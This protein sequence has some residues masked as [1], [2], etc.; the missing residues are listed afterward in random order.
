MKI[1]LISAFIVIS[2]LS[3]L[4]LGFRN[5]IYFK[6]NSSFEIFSSVFREIANNYVLEI[7]P[8]IIIKKSIEGMLSTLDPYTGFY[9]T[10]MT[11]DLDI[12]TSGYYTGFGFTVSKFDD[13][14]TIVDLRD[15]NSAFIQGIRIG[16]RLFQ[17]DTAM[18]LNFTGEQIKQFT[19]GE[20]GTK[21]TLRILR[22]G[23]K[24]TLSFVLTRESIALPNVS[25]YGIASNSIAYIKIESFT[26]T[27]AGEVKN[28]LNRLKNQYDIQGVILDFRDNPGGLLSSAISIAELFLPKNSLIVSTKGKRPG[29]MLEY[30]SINDPKDIDI[31]LAILI[32]GSSASASEVVAGAIQDLDR[33]ILVGQRS[34]G[35]G[36]VQSVFN[37]PYNTYLKMT[38]SKYYTPSGRCIQRIKFGDLYTNDEITINTDTTIFYTKNGRPV[39]ELRGIIPDIIVVQDTIPD[40]ITSLYDKGLLF[41]FA[42][43][44]AAKFD[45]IPKDFTITNQVFSEFDDFLKKNEFIYLSRSG[46][47]LKQIETA[48]ETDNYSIKAR[49]N[50][51]T[52]INTVAEEDS[53]ELKKHKAVI[54]KYLRYEI[55]RRFFS[56]RNMI[57]IAMSGDKELNTAI[58]ILISDK[59][60]KILS[61]NK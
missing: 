58:N 15:N 56:S 11:D 18:V 55:L 34:F 23:I 53:K 30:R 2:I 21:S 48:L 44:Y 52:L 35:K 47:H 1:K 59:Y 27:T 51:V 37:L 36:L 39:Y 3:L 7:D 54:S 50:L 29:D 16:D 25:Y 6:I 22:D 8:E 14:L 26:R 12:I 38:T 32:N 19:R 5:S 9:S 42:N 49:N 45:T 33:G 61:I 41:K 20:I 17:I 46:E 40:I 4:L 10:D 31:P 13:G 43:Y 57:E 60:S 24:D 28:A